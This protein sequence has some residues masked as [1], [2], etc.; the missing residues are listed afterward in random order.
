MTPDTRPAWL[1]RQHTPLADWLL[2]LA[3]VPV[4]WAVLYGLVVCFVAAVRLA[5]NWVGGCG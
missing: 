4:S 1:P 3:L 2:L 5:W